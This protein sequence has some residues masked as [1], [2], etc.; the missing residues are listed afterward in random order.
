MVTQTPDDPVSTTTQGIGILI[1]RLRDNTLQFLTNAIESRLAPQK[2]VNKFGFNPDI[3]IGT[4]DIWT[5]GG[6]WVPPTQAR[7]HQLVSTDDSDNGATATGALTVKVFGLDTNFDEIDETVTLDGDTNVPTIQEFL[8]IYR[9]EVLTVGSGEINAGTIT[10]TA[11]TDGTVTAEIAI[12]DGQTQMAIYTIPNGFTGY[13]NVLDIHIDPTNNFLGTL[14]IKSK[15]DNT[16]PWR[17]RFQTVHTNNQS[18]EHHVFNPPK[19]FVAQEDIVFEFTSSAN[20]IA[21]S[22]SFD[23]QLEEI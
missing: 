22:A 17:T 9:I 1:K 11:D 12:G 8:R 13:M 15:R 10:A 5:H 23:I 18:S 16:A 7:I 2:W 19:V 3:D 21:V 4:E 6:K 20:N 14:K